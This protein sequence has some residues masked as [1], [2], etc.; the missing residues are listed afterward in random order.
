MKVNLSVLTAGAEAKITMANG[1][2]FKLGTGLIGA[3]I[4]ANTYDVIDKRLKF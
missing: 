2:S 1:I 4:S 3:G